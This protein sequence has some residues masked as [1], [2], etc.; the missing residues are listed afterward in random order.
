MTRW[1]ELAELLSRDWLE[2]IQETFTGLLGVMLVVTDMEGRPVNRPTRPCGLFIALSQKPNAIQYFIADWRALSTVVDL[3]PSLRVSHASLL[4]ARS[5]IAV[6]KEVKGMVIAGCIAPEEWPPS[7]PEVAGITS[8][9]D[10]SPD[11]IM[12]YVN[13]VYNLDKEQQERVLSTIPRVAAL[14]A[15]FVDDRKVLVDKLDAFAG[16][17]QLYR[18]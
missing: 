6:G 5:M 2:V 9:F 8:R 3:T 13:D 14:I 7:P 1:W 17:S 4:C 11:F 16:L 12:K 18:Q 15:Q 10:V